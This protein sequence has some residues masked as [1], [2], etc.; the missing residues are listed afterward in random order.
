MYIFKLRLEKYTANIAKV[1]KN[2]IIIYNN[3]K[4]N[5]NLEWYK[6][7]IKWERKEKIKRLDEIS[8]K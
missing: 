8:N 6:E 2:K 7:W 3:P 4:C 5:T 1:L